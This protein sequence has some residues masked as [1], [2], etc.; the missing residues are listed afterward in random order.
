MFCF[1]KNHTCIFKTIILTIIIYYVE[2]NFPNKV[3][4][5]KKICKGSFY[6]VIGSH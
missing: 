2:I 5:L 4:Y 6:L 3:W 1:Q